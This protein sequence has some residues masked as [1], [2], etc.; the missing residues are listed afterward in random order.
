MALE[1]LRAVRRELGALMATRLQGRHS[2]AGEAMYRLL[3]QRE[4]SLL[5]SLED[6]RGVA[7]LAARA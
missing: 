3:C 4:R 6:G 2:A 7:G 1:E 5:A